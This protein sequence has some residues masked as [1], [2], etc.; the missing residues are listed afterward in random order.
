METYIFQR[1]KM[2]KVKIDIFSFCFN[3]D[4]WNFLLLICLLS[5]PL[6]LIWLLCKSLNL[7]GC[8]GDKRVN[9]RE[10]NLLLRYHKVD[11]A[12]TFHTCL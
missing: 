6:P 2:G 9:F 3:G 8:Q 12:D 7:I 1:L 4:I 10:R 11:E 5:S